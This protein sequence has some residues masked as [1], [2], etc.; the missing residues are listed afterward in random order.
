M[1][2]EN[3]IERDREKKEDPNLC[4]KVNMHDASTSLAT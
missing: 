2:R 4:I 1:I 3:K